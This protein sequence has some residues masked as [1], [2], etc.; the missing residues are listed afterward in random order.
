MFHPTRLGVDLPVLLLIH[1]DHLA[2]TIEDHTA[3]AGGSLIDGS[4]KVRHAILLEAEALVL[5]DLSGLPLGRASQE[6]FAGHAFL[7]LG[8]DFVDGEQALGGAD[9]RQPSVNFN[10][11]GF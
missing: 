8:L 9:G 1:G 10:L 6:G 4:N 11:S 3:S 5:G 2:N 7:P